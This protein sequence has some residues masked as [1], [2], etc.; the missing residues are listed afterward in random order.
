MHKFA[1]A[2][3]VTV[4]AVTFG[5]EIRTLS[6]ASPRLFKPPI[7]NVELNDRE[8]RPNGVLAA[9]Q[10]VFGGGAGGISG[11]KTIPYWLKT[12]DFTY[13]FMY[14]D[15]DSVQFY[16]CGY[17]PDS[18]PAGVLV[19]PGGHQGPVDVSILTSGEDNYCYSAAI[20]SQYGMELG[21][22]T[23]NLEHKNG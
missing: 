22:Y 10:V 6:Q 21:R 5:T 8:P 15:S 1:V 11:T 12:H 13:P 16:A 20:P 14:N 18:P 7:V 4:V 23:L 9:L 17:P 19:S 2:V 3:L